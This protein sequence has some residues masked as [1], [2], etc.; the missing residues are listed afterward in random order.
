MG[1]DRGSFL[2]GGL[3]F[4]LLVVGC[5]GFSHRY[6]GL[7]G[8]FY[9]QGTLLGPK[10]KDDLPFKACAPNE[11]SKNP[12]VVM[13]ARDFFALKADY[14]STKQRLKECEAR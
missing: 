7:M 10:P 8:V 6:F 11:D 13:F 4:L 5:A 1:I 2:M 12:C 14:E 9:D 3:F